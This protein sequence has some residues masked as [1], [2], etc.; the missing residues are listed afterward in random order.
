M[1]PPGFELFKL[2]DQL[3]TLLLLKPVLR[4]EQQDGDILW[5]MLAADPTRIFPAFRDLPQYNRLGRE[6]QP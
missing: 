4:N 6:A 5:C 2:D 3:E 1:I